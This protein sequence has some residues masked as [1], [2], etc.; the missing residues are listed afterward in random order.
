MDNVHEI[1]QK[2]HCPWAIDV[3]GQW[4]TKSTRPGFFVKLLKLCFE[5]LRVFSYIKNDLDRK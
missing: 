2:C 1:T 5:V 4:S 3:H